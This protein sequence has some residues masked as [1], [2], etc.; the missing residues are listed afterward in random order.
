M[1]SGPQGDQTSLSSP[2]DPGHPGRAAPWRRRFPSHV[3]NHRS[4]SADETPSHSLQGRRPCRGWETLRLSELSRPARVPGK[5]SQG[6]AALSSQMARGLGQTRGTARNRSPPVWPPAPL[7][8]LGHPALSSLGPPREARAHNPPK[9]LWRL[10]PPRLPGVPSLPPPSPQPP[11]ATG[12][13]LVH[14]APP[15]LAHP[16]PN[17]AP[18]PPPDY[19]P[20]SLGWQHSPTTD[21]L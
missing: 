16:V 21:A 20:H 7:L 11:A 4:K 14:P 8:E 19:I 2:D 3:P 1:F 18:P 13:G 17:R 12:A 6:F 10:P 9:G 15:A 5:H